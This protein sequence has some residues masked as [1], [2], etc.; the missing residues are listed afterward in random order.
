MTTPLFITAMILRPVRNTLAILLVVLLC[1]LP[2]SV[3]AEGKEEALAMLREGKAV[4]IL[5]HALAPGIG[6]PSGFEVGDCSTQRNLNEEGRAQARA[7]KPFLRRHGIEQARVLSSQWC[8]GL[9]TAVRMDVGEVKEFPPLN[10]FFGGRGDREMQT[11]ETIERVNAMGD[12]M[13]IILV[14]HQ[15]NTTALTGVYPSSNEGVIVR[16]PL[17]QGAGVLARIIP[18]AE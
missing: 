7:W 13:P 10:S 14:S 15:V 9:D 5:R 16:F 4:M 6:D 12:G 18:E 8:R 1:L 17:E 11:R 3:S 2:L